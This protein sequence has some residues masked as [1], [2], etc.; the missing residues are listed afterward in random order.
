MTKRSSQINGPILNNE[1]PFAFFQS[2]SR[3]FQL[4]YFVTEM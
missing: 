4:A 1:R 3:L 2:L